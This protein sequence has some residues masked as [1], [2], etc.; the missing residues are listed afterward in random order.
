MQDHQEPQL[1]DG[2]YLRWLL[3]V[4]LFDHRVL[5]LGEM[6]VLIER[7]G[8]RVRGR[9]SKT[10]SDALRWEMRRGRVVRLGRGRYAAGSMPRSTLS[11]QRARVRRLRVERGWRDR[12]A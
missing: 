11:W 12:A 8:F 4:C 10:V 9:P 2:R 6:L 7:H 5:T 3:T 1:I